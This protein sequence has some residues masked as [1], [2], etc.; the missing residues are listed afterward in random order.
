MNPAIRAKL[1]VMMF[2]EY[3]I[4]GAWLPLLGLYIGEDYLN[5]TRHPAGLGLQRLRDCVD[6]GDVLRRS[7][8]GPLLRPGEVPG[9]QPPDRWPRDAGPDLSDDLLA[10]LRPMLL[11]CFF[12][13]PTMSVTNAI[14]FAYVKDPQKDFR[15]IR[16]WGTIGWIAASWPFI[17]IPIDWAKVPS[18]EQAGGFIS[19]MGT[20]L[21]PQD[22]RRDGRGTGQHVHRRGDHVPGP[23]R[24]LPDLPAHAAG[25]GAGASLRPSG[26]VQASEGAEH[27]GPV[28]RHVPRFARALLLLL[29]DQPLLCPASDCPPTGS[30]RR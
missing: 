3:V 1:C 11:H 25:P 19:W 20:A 28:H 7:T 14:A 12:Y 8:R 21:G 23:G 27:P 9:L 18:M 13:V 5:F 30:H 2:L 4:Y 10:V 22:G 24:I 29:L 6:H 17:F 26:G 16:V 15:L